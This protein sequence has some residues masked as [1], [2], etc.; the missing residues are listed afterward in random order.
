M[1]GALALRKP[2]EAPLFNA[3]ATIPLT[4]DGDAPVVLKTL[5]KA[6]SAILAHNSST[7]IIRL[8]DRVRAVQ[9]ITFVDVPDAG[10]ITF[11]FPGHGTTGALLFS[12]GPS[13]LETLLDAIFGAGVCSVTGDGFTDTFI[14]LFQTFE[15]AV[16]LATI[17]V[18]TLVNGVTPVVPTFAATVVGSAATWEYLLPP[19]APF[20]LPVEC[21]A[22][23]RISAQ[24]ADT[25]AS[26]GF[27]SLNFLG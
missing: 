10:S 22:G 6:A 11:T 2:T 16:P 3:N 23:S 15:G 5:T 13:E 7:K 17:G 21:A 8:S 26:T 14:I 19:N 24:S 20:I 25:A 9:T 4:D 12:E 27:L 1:K 18:N